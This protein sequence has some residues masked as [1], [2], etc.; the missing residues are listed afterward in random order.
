MKR[1]I[2][3][4]ILTVHLAIC[5]LL[6]FDW[7]FLE[8]IYLGFGLTFI[9]LY[10]LTVPAVVSGITVVCEINQLTKKHIDVIDLVCGVIGAVILCAYLLSAL[11][12]FSGS[13]L[14]SVVYAILPLG[15]VSILGC[16]IGKI[17]Y[18]KIKTKKHA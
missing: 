1:K 12:V 13:P 15:T 14:I 11:G 2:I 4:A 16:Q 10:A 9:I 18:V 17:I 7:G 3:L 8:G 5:M 6:S